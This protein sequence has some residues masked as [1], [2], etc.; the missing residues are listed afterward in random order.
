[1]AV[2]GG[3]DYALLAAGPA[4]KRPRAARRV[5]HVERGRGVFLERAGHRQRLG[6]AFEH[7]ATTPDFR[8]RY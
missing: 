5:G 6:A 7:F 4:R 3:E 8:K 1:L 2:T